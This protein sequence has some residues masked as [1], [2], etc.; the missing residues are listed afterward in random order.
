MERPHPAPRRCPA[1]LEN[2]VSQRITVST[3]ENNTFLVNRRVS[4]EQ[5]ESRAQPVQPSPPL[6]SPPTFLTGG[7]HLAG[8]R[9]AP[10]GGRARST[11]PP[12]R[13]KGLR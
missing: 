7:A 9:A 8:Y 12:P 13:R 3:I 1:F 11:Q 5:K 4:S 10:P 6:P 2:T